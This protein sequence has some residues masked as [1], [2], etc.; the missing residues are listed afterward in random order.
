MKQETA[1]PRCGQNDLLEKIKIEK[2]AKDQAY[3]FILSMGLLEEF[4]QFCK[5]NPADIDYHSLC[6]AVLVRMA[7][8]AGII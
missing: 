5:A 3:Y 8:D 6:V 1:T 2:N 4:S 7:K